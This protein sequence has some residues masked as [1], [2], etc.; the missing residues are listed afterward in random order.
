[1]ISLFVGDFAVGQKVDQWLIE[2]LG[3][4]EERLVDFNKAAVQTAKVVKKMN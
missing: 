1:M 4:G 2:G 3:Y